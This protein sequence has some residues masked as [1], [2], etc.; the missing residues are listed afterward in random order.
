[1]ILVDTI[2]YIIWLWKFLDTYLI[3]SLFLSQSPTSSFSFLSTYIHIHTIHIHIHTI[4]TYIHILNLL[5]FLPSPL[6]ATTQL[7][8]STTLLCQHMLRNI[9]HIYSH[10]V[11]VG[12][13]HTHT[14]T[15]IYIFCFPPFLF[16]QWIFRLGLG[17]LVS[18][19]VFQLSLSPFFSSSP[20]SPFVLRL[21]CSSEVLS[22]DRICS[23]RRRRF[24]MRAFVSTFGRHH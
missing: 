13:I 22:D 1:M 9:T 6:L 8:K 4:H 18:S 16:T 10:Y 7:T 17:F 20:P 12:H 15:H 24:R 3:F 23:C 5:P 19:S 14:H 21:V 2:I 11:C